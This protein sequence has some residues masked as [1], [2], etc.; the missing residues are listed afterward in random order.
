MATPAGICHLCGEDTKLSFE[1]I[2]PHSAF[3][4]QPVFIKT[5]EE[6][7]RDEPPFNKGG[8]KQQRGFGSYTL[9]VKCNNDT[10]AWYGNAYVSWAYQGMQHAHY[11]KRVPDM[12]F[13]FRIFPGRVI[14]QILCMFF[15]LNNNKFQ[16]AQP[17]L[18]KLVLDREARF[19]QGQGIRIYA[20]YTLSSQIRAT[21]VSFRMNVVDGGPAY[22]TS[23]LSFPP[24][25]YVM[26]FDCPPPDP[27]LVDISFFANYRFNDWQELSMRFPVLPVESW[28]P[29]DYRTFGS[30]SLN[31]HKSS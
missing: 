15:S 1:H 2:P 30:S 9:C 21:G 20:Y 5:F 7:V 18:K 29:G 28:I 31:A 4:D 22:L 3:N 16:S 26:T 8:R 23:E 14:K 17:G 11:A 27:R 12:I 10:G 24:W 6:V 19:L 25:G 13:N